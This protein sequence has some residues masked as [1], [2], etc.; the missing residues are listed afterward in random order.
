MSTHKFIDR[1]CVVILVCTV[2]LTILFMNGEALGIQV[3]SDQDT[4]ANEGSVWFTDN[5]LDGN[6]DSENAVRITLEGTDASIEGS[7]AYV[8]DGNLVIASS[9]TYVVSGELTDGSLI[10]DANDNSKVW[11]R[12]IRSS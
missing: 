10:V 1:I 12:P 11:I 2:L 4:D 9:G 3:I 5:D 8:I 7:G 6:W